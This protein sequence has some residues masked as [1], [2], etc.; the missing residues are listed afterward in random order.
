MKL[1]RDVFNLTIGVLAT[2]CYRDGMEVAMNWIVYVFWL[3]MFAW[4]LSKTLTPYMFD[5]DNKKSARH[6][7]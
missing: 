5:D 4:D 7:D 6:K 2:I 1:V 3:P